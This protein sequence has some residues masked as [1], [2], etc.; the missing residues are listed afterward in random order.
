MSD[1]ISNSAHLNDGAPVK[2]G[3]FIQ[4]LKDTSKEEIVEA[5]NSMIFYNSNASAQA[6][7]KSDPIKQ[8]PGIVKLTLPINWSKA[9]PDLTGANLVVDG[10][11]T[12]W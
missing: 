10:G 8:L 7:V 12:T 3:L 1:A 5:L 4:R 2:L 6:N 9:F 11:W